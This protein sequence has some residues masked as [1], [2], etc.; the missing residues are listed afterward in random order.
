MCCASLQ[1]FTSSPRSLQAYCAGV[2]PVGSGPK[3][4][5]GRRQMPP[6]SQLQDAKPA[7][8]TGQ[9]ES[10]LHARVQPLTT[11]WGDASH[12]AAA[13]HAEVSEASQG[14]SAFTQTRTAGVPT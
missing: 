12:A 5:G 9:S 7:A 10:E 14:A 3:T 8:R 11:I 13:M 1:T 4:S 6:A 2:A